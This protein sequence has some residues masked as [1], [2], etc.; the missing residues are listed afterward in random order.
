MWN[1]LTDSLRH[2]WLL[3]WLLCDHHCSMKRRLLCH[4]SLKRAKTNAPTAP[5][6]AT[7][8]SLSVSLLNLWLFMKDWGSRLLPFS[9]DQQIYTASQYEFRSFP[10]IR[11]NSPSPT[12]RTEDAPTRWLNG[13]WQKPVYGSEG[14]LSQGSSPRLSA[15][16]QPRSKPTPF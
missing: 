13:E 8:A 7:L 16:N 2:A 12:L 11:R 5:R 4:L 3:I 10:D 9:S 15:S 6:R 14:G 1:K